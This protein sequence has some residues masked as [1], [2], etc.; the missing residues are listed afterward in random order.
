MH[1]LTIWVQ[2]NLEIDLM[3]KDLETPT[4]VL[5]LREARM[6][7]KELQAKEYAI[8]QLIN[9]RSGVKEPESYPRRD[10]KRLSTSEILDVG[11]MSK[12]HIDPKVW[13]DYIETIINK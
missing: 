7:R 4:L 6:E 8:R 9:A 11:R 3:Y 12:Q 1:H 5:L 10:T 13:V 2:S